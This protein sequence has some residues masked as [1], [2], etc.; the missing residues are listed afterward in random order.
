M[1]RK[2]REQV[3]RELD[4]L[5]EDAV[6]ARV[7]GAGKGRPSLKLVQEWLARREKVNGELRA[8]SDQVEG[9]QLSAPRVRRGGSG[10]PPAAGDQS[11]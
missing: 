4:E 7:S 6:R 11:R 10:E 9:H 2:T 3:W 1:P 5:G 8:T